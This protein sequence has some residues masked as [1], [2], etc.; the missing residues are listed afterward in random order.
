[1]EKVLNDNVKKQSLK[2]IIRAILVKKII[3]INGYSK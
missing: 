1:M 3:I 2:Q